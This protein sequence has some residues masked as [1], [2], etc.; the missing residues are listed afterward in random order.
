METP[1]EAWWGG[2]ASLIY[3]N[4]VVVCYWTFVLVIVHNKH[5]VGT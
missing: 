3:L 4:R 5:H 2:T 1:G